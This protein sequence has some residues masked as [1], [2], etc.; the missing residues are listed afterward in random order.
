MPRLLE[1]K[2]TIPAKITALEKTSIQSHGCILGTNESELGRESWL[3][4]KLMNSI[5][6]YFYF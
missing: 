5:E 2:K 3:E 6:P 1:T 4:N